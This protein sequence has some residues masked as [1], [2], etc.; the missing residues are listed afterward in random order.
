MTPHPIACVFFGLLI[1]SGTLSAQLTW[2]ADSVTDGVQNGTG[3][4][5]LVNNLWY[6]GLTNTTW[7]NSGSAIAA[8]GSSASRTGGTVTVDGTVKVGGLRFNA[9]SAS[10]AAELPLTSAYTL[11]GGTLQFADNAIIEAANNTSSGSSGVL[12]INVN[13]VLIGNGL[14]IQRA[15]ETRINAFQYVRFS[16]TNPD[17]KG[18]LNINA[19]AADNGI[20][21]L[22]AGSN[23]VSSLERIIV[24]NG[25]VLAAG[26]T[27]NTYAMPIILAGIGQGSGAL[28]VDSSNMVFS[29]EITLAEDAAIQTN[30]NIVNTVI[31]GPIT[32]VGGLQRFASSVNSILTLNGTSTYQGATTI[33]RTGAAAP[34]I[35]VVN[36]AAENAPQ[37]DMLYNGVETAGALNM[38]G[39]TGGTATL[40]LQGADLTDNSQRFGD[41]ALTGNR[42][43][44]ILAAGHGGSMSVGLGN[45]TRTTP[46]SITF[47]SETPGT[48][49]TTTPDGFLGPWA[50]LVNKAGHGTWANVQG[51]LLTA[52]TGSTEYVTGESLSSLG[53][54]AD[55]GISASSTGNVLGGSGTYQVNTLSMTDAT[56][57]RTVDIGTGN[58]LRLGSTGG[59]QLTEDALSLDIGI[60]GSAGALRAGTGT[61][62]MWL[63]N[64]SKTGTLTIHS[65]IENNGSSALTLYF[66]GTGKTV[67][68]GANT[69]TGA[70]QISSGEVEAAHSTALGS[71]TAATTVQSN[72]T[73]R[74]AGDIS[75]TKP[76]TLNGLGA[77]GIGALVNT[78][79][80]NELNQ[81]VTVAQTSRFTSE[82]GTL[83]FKGATGTTAVITASASGATTFFGGAGDFRIQG[84]LNAAANVV[85]KDGA[86]TLTFAGT[87]VFTAAMTQTAGTIHLDFS[88]PTSPTNNILYNGIAT[89]VA[90]TM[91]G[92]LLRLTGRAGEANAQTFGTLTVTNLANI[93]LAPNGAAS[94]SLSFGSITRSFGGLLGLD[95]PAGSS[96]RVAGGTDNALLTANGRA[97]AYIRDSVNGDEWAATGAI[98]GGTRPVIKL[99]TLSGAAGYTASTLD[100]LS[101]N[102]DIA[103]TVTTTNLGTD[104]TL[105]SLRFA[106][107]QAT[108]ITDGDAVTTLT[109]GGILVS[110]TVGANTSTISTDILRAA[111]STTSTNPDLTIIQNNTAAPLL[112]TSAITSS[113]GSTGASATVSLAKAGPGLVILSGANT[114]TGNVRVYEGSIQFGGTVSTS[115]EFLIGSGATSA[116]VILGLP[117]TPFT[118]SSV[119]YIQTVGIGTDNR[120]VGGSTALS[121]LT[122]T[123]SVSVPSDFSK[124]YIG[125]SGT[126]ENNL[127]LRLAS[128]N[129]LLK[130][131]ANNTYIGRTILSRGT[132]E[133]EK[134]ADAGLPSSLGTGDINPSAAT[135]TLSDA[136]TSA[137]GSTAISVIRYVGSTNSTT[138]R[139]INLTNSDVERD[140][141][142]VEAVLENTG[143]GTLKFTSPF[144]T[145]GSNVVNRVLR[146]TG[147]NTGLNEVVGIS[148]ASATILAR[149][150]KD[151]VGT[152]AITGSSTYS[153]GTAINSGTLLVNNDPATGSAT[154]LGPVVVTSA[155]LGGTGRIAPALDKPIYITGGTLNPGLG[156][157]SNE[158]GKLTLATLGSG[159][160]SLENSSVLWLD[161]FSGAGLGDNTASASAADLLAISGQASFGF[162]TTLRVLNPNGMT[163]WAAN[164]QW[165]LFDWTGLTGVYGEI[166]TYDLPLLPDGLIWNTEDLLTT[167]VLSISLVPEPGRLSLL[168]LAFT[169]LC[170][171]RRRK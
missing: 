114:F 5:N 100:S 144:L 167:G 82:S 83:V 37:S 57:A 162:G 88:A 7:D 170:L 67:L 24:Q 118:A 163:G 76:I 38:I 29:G 89:P 107:P 60:P 145:G 115:I 143:T 68:A 66:N 65:V 141:A 44:L 149:I 158:A 54:A 41:L 14:T 80:V 142:A 33:G 95:L 32:G 154:G 19:R 139:P 129:S 8:F 124:G 49:S 166:S 45:I 20:F 128:L 11:S 171:R 104:T 168:A 102:A 112:I 25:S 34:G 18:V 22:L 63:S 105:S 47:V 58:V 169:T 74:L 123:G 2:D 40:I 35:T 136:T 113:L 64:L 96:L 15:D 110:S 94:L 72:G 77:N 85:T 12:F 31:A 69:Y 133:V 147:T 71:G 53:A 36:F 3:T 13:S 51:G 75:L 119:D 90:Y 148:D 117:D 78:S 108:L 130:L 46:A 116:K 151:G 9:L 81:V 86:G 27:S 135:L 1:A 121:R 126:N 159:M 56:S 79:G 84:Q 70:T 127:E 140:I 62:Q 42:S 160:L 10:A 155:T 125:G 101:G 150:E 48:I 39:G 97:F 156:R 16:G 93:S 17:L 165:Q 161:L 4:W 122:L 99:S 132:I 87:Q 152:W 28:R 153:G 137:V 138:N 134:L 61:A 103:S 23:T 59:I 55:V 131:G 111:P 50:A 21:M 52:F 73:L 164:D 146:L 26:G 92:T 6:N 157:L 120:I 109:T 91:N 30:R 106:Q 98:S 43:N